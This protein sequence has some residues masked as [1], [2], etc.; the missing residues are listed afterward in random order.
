M[1]VV[2]DASAF[3]AAFANH[4][5]LA[6]RI[7]AFGIAGRFAILVSEDILAEVRRLPF[8]PHVARNKGFDMAAADRIISRL[9]PAAIGSAPDSLGEAP[10]S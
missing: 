2:V 1:R 9:A 3:G 8:N 5:G 6:A 7:I 4:R 10:R